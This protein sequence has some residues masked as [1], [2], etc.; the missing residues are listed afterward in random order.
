MFP[1]RNLLLA[2]VCLQNAGCNVMYLTQMDDNPQQDLQCLSRIWRQGQTEEEVFVYTVMVSCLAELTHLQCQVDKAG[3]WRQI[4]YNALS[5]GD[6]PAVLD[7]FFFTKDEMP[8]VAGK[9]Y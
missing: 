4:E 7:I 8:D 9:E 5:G 1:A 2:V 6:A 3:S